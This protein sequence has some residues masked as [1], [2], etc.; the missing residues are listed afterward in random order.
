LQHVPASIVVTAGRFRDNRRGTI[1]VANL[2]DDLAEIV[3]D[4]P[5]GIDA[6]ATETRIVL[7]G[8]HLD[9]LVKALD[10]ARRAR[11]LTS[12]QAVTA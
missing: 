2:A 12:V 8:D 5:A 6:P 7:S 1:S 3:I 11:T 4:Q 10:T 9:L